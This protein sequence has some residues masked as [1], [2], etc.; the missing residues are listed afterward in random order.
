MGGIDIAISRDTEA[1]AYLSR[2]NIQPLP[3]EFSMS[4]KLCV[5]RNCAELVTA[6]LEP[7]TRPKTKLAVTCGWLRQAMMI[8]L[9]LSDTAIVDH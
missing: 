8:G 5:W 1:Q 7:H 2:R 9:N 6:Y 4:A 3:T